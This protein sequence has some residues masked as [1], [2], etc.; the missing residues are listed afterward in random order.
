MVLQ[1]KDLYTGQRSVSALPK[2]A[3]TLLIMF[4]RNTNSPPGLPTRS[5]KRLRQ[6]WTQRNEASRTIEQI[7]R[8][9]EQKEPVA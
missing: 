5:T 8:N 9:Q 3:L 7:V 6:A 1:I 2:S 4:R